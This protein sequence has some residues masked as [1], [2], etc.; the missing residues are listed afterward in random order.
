MKKLLISLLTAAFASTALA[1]GWLTDYEAALAKAKETKTPVL[2]V[3]SGSDWCPPC[4]ML[5]NEILGTKE[6][7]AAM[8]EGKFVPLFVDFPRRKKI[9]AEQKEQ[10]FILL[11]KFNPD[12]AFPTLML[13]DAEGKVLAQ[14]QGLTNFFG[15]RVWNTPKDLLSWIAKRGKY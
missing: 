15:M 13:L 2:L 14:Q 9:S 3:F 7:L 6:F 10:N 11:E 4:I 5:E 8:E 1:A 12:G